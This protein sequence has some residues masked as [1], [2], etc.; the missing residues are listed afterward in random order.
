MINGAGVDGKAE[1]FTIL[2]IYRFFRGLPSLTNR[3]L[4]RTYIPSGHG[5]RNP[6]LGA[7][8]G[9]LHDTVPSDF[10]LNREHY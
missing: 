7:S 4:Q 2:R 5:G 8:Y 3:P 10:T 9:A 6:V 1:D